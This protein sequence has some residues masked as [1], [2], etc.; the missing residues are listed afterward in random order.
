MTK[1]DFINQIRS[2]N[3]SK[4]EETQLWDL[5]YDLEDYYTNN[6]EFNEELSK[7]IIRIITDDYLLLLKFLQFHLKI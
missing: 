3:L 6:Q 5:Y 1:H 7:E 4:E 2:L